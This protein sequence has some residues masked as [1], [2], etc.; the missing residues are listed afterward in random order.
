VLSG[1]N[2]PYLSM[3]IVRSRL[4]K[5]AGIGF[6]LVGGVVVGAAVALAAFWAQVRV[7]R[8]AI[9]LDGGVVV[10]ASAGY[11]HCFCCS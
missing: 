6:L 7:G 10:V 2:V 8:G 11:L 1:S 4:V 9:D 3:T 5:T